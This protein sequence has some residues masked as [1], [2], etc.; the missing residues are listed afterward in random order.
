MDGFRA[1]LA[2]LGWSKSPRS[3]SI[4]P[5]NVESLWT[6]FLLKLTAHGANPIMRDIIRMMGNRTLEDLDIDGADVQQLLDELTNAKD[7]LVDHNGY[8][9]RHHVLGSSPRVPGHAFEENSDLPL[10]E[11][12]GWQRLRW[13]R[14]RRSERAHLEGPAK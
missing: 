9:P 6:L 12:V 10:L 8:L 2:W 11:N 3:S 13:K 5:K 7:T 14:T 4:K 1:Q